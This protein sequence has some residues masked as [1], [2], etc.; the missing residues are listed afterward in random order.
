MDVNLGDEL[1]SSA[2]LDIDERRQRFVSAP[3]RR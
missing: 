3:P 1:V 2:E